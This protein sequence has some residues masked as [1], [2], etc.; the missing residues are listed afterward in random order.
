LAA[1]HAPGSKQLPQIAGRYRQ[2]MPIWVHSADFNF[3]ISFFSHFC[4]GLISSAFSKLAKAPS[5]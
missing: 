3:S 1:G 4:R 5:F 2:N